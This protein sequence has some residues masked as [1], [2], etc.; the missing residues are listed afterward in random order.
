MVRAQNPDG[1]GAVDWTLPEGEIGPID[2]VVPLR[3]AIVDRDDVRRAHCPVCVDEEPMLFAVTEHGA[4][5][6]RCLGCGLL[7]HVDR[8]RDRVTGARPLAPWGERPER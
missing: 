7:W 2:A 3:E 5:Y 8:E 6:D 1:A 4:R